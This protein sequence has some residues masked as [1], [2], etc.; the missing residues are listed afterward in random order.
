MPTSQRS[1]IWQMSRAKNRWSRSTSLINP[2]TVLASSAVSRRSIAVE[3]TIPRRLRKTRPFD[4]GSNCPSDIKESSYRSVTQHPLA[5]PSRDER[6]AIGS[7]HPFYSA[8]S[9]VP[10]QLIHGEAPRPPGLAQRFESHVQTDFVAVLERIVDGLG[11]VV[12]AHRLA[13]DA[14]SLDA[15][16]QCIATEATNV[17][18]RIPQRGAAAATVERDPNLVR[19]LST[20]LMKA[21]RGQQTDHCLRGRCGNECETVMLRHWGIG[22]AVASPCNAIQLSTTTHPTQTL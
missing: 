18:A 11:D 14:V 1:C 19:K 10:V 15:L 16:S 21:Q 6:L 9:R 2:S 5:H 17:Q 7:P 8:N 20:D 13:L 3:S 4:P 12:H 22:Q